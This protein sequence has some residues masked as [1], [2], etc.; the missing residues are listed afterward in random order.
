M[1]WE[2]LQVQL[3]KYAGEY[4][5]RVLG[6]LVALL[7]A[8]L[9]AGWAGRVTY[10]ALQKANFDETLSKFGSKLSRWTVLLVAVLACLGVFGIQTTSFAALIGAAGLAVGL[11]F[12]GTLSNF[13]A[14]VMLL[15]FRPFKVGDVITAAGQTGTVDEIELFT[16]TLDTGDR[17]RFVLPNNIV[18]G[19]VIENKS[20]HPQRRVDITVGVDYGA[21][22]DRVR[23]VL[24]A[25]AQV[26]GVLA[27]PEPAIVLTDL[28]GSSV[29]WAVK[30]WV[31]TPDYWAVRERLLVAIKKSLDAAGIG[32]PYPTMD[33]NLSQPV[34]TA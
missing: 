8:R 31:N 22:V 24:A 23:E 17:R 11:A 1:N 14:G 9:L 2:A 27:D 13:A 20:H 15:V 6:V 5:P 29:D 30:A 26:E 28:G 25:A 34:T 12:Q 3:W 32:I 33:I 18:F 19:S 4:A 16:T 7:A 10:A 21:D